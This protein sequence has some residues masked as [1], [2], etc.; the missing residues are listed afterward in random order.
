M[1]CPRSFDV[2]AE[3]WL[4]SQPWATAAQVDW[5]FV[6]DCLREAARVGQDH[7]CAEWAHLIEALTP[8]RLPDEPTNELSEC[9]VLKAECC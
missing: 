6:I 5:S 2:S 7:D 4:W 1:D 3:D 9:S 8:V